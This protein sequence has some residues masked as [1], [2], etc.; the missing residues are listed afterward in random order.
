MYTTPYKKLQYSHLFSHKRLLEFPTLILEDCINDLMHFSKTV[1]LA[2][3][4][5]NNSI[6]LHNKKS[7]I[8]FQVNLNIINNN[9]AQNV[10]H[11]YLFILFRKL[12]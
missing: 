9:Y 8:D 4:I 12:V 3:A 7:F 2:N 6:P 5:N 10:L 11:L 1:S